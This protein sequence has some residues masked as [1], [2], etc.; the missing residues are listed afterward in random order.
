MLSDVLPATW[1]NLYFFQL[2]F[3]LTPTSEHSHAYDCIGSGNKH[4]NKKN[5]PVCGLER[6]QSFLTHP[7]QLMLYLFH[8]DQVDVSELIRLNINK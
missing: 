6:S 8:V 3:F 7:G 5:P 1:E 2:H 4:N